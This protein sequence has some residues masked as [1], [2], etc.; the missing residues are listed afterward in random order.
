MNDWKSISQIKEITTKINYKRPFD[1]ARA[2][3]LTNFLQEVETSFADN[4]RV[5]TAHPILMI[6]RNGGFSEPTFTIGLWASFSLYKVEYHVEMNENPFFP[7]LFLKSYRLDNKTK[8]CE[9]ADVMNAEMYINCDW[10]AEQKTI[11]QLTT[12]MHRLFADAQQRSGNTYVMEI[13]ACSRKEKQ[14]IYTH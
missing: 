9:Y 6:N 7:A 1:V 3:A 4:F 2:I 11:N 8:C 14:T 5:E 10:N 12:N 13:P